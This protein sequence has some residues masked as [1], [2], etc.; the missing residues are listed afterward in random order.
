MMPPHERRKAKPA[1][2]RHD[3]HSALADIFHN[4]H[5]SALGIGIVAVYV[6]AEDQAALVRLADIEVAGAKGDNVRQ[7]RLDRFGDESLKHMAFDGKTQ[8]RHGRDA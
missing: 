7:K 4:R 8:I 5:V 3:R 6:A 1:D 2:H